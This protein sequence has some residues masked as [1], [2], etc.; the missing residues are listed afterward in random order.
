[1]GAPGKVERRTRIEDS[2]VT[3]L[4]QDFALEIS[5][6]TDGVARKAIIKPCAPMI[7]CVFGARRLATW[8]PN[9]LKCKSVS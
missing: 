1:M 5:E 3:L 9:A 2:Q 8:L 4:E 7:P 6:P